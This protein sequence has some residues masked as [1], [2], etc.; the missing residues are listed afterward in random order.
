ML[1]SDPKRDSTFEHPLDVPALCMLH[2]RQKSC[3]RLEQQEFLP[4]QIFSC[5]LFFL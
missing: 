4:Q 3:V 2:V 1:S 5:E